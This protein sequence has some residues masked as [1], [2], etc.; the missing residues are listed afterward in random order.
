MSARDRAILRSLAERIHPGDAGAHNNLGVVF[1]QKGLVDEAILAFERAL[2]L[3]PRLEVARRNAE[4]AYRETGQFE[5]RVQR[6]RQELE[7]NP[8][9]PSIRDALARTYLLGGRPAA[10]AREW[11]SLLADRPEDPILHLKLAWAESRSGRPDAAIRLAERAVALSPED[12]KARFEHASLLRL[13]DRLEE[14]ERVVRAGLA[15]D[16]ELAAGHALLARVLE[17]AGDEDGAR[18]A[19]ERAEELDPSARRQERHLSLEPYLAGDEPGD[20][21]S[22]SGDGESRPGG[23]EPETVAGPLGPFARAMRLRR[24]GDLD[25]AAQTLERALGDGGDF[26]ARQALAE[27]RLLQGGLDQAAEAYAALLEEEAA[28]PKLWNERGVALHRLGRLDEAVEAYRQ[29]VA[30]DYDYALGWNNLGIARAQRRRTRRSGR[31]GRPRRAAR[32]RRSCGTWG[33]S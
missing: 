15:L 16:D 25:G 18:A 32:R 23:E 29:A 13:A 22:G 2:E 30:L 11:A 9:D 17:A 8:G 5:R 6:L 4:L 12:P 20:G 1:Y 31:C 21:E 10:A 3:D 7:A 33:C 24:G 28:S 27:I 26:A 19:R 14:A